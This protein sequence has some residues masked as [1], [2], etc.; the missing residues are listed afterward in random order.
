[1]KTRKTMRTV[2]AAV[3]AVLGL[4]GCDG[5]GGG[6]GGAL[7]QQASVSE[8]G[9]FAQA[10]LSVAD[11]EAALDYCAAEVIDWAYDAASRTLVL[12]NERVLLNCCGEHAI[13][14]EPA[15][16]GGLLVTE[17]DDPDHG[18]RCGCMC[19]FDFVLQ[20]EDVDAAALP[21]TLER[22]VGDDEDAS[23]TKWQGTIDPSQG[24]G[25]IVVDGGDVGP[26]CGDGE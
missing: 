13:A 17:T 24:A 19:V 5:D 22:L 14:A 8:C 18:A 26:W 6:S 12:R 16:G 2:A 23:G 4:A 10:A 15:E 11:D 7:A 3:A 25:T 20:L 9:G 1:M 21:L